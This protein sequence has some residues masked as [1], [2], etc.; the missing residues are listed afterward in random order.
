MAAGDVSPVGLVFGTARR[1][2][3]VEAIG[4][5]FKLMG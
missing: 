5:V 2:E 4:Y 1:V 3:S